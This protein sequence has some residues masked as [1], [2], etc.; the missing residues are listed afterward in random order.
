MYTTTPVK[1]LSYYLHCFE[2][3]KRDA[4]NGG[5]PHKPVLLLSIIQLFEQGIF[6]NQHVFLLPEL[7]A[8]FKSNWNRLVHTTHHPIFALPYYHM[9]SEPF[10]MLIP[11]AGCEKWIESKG[12]MR[13]LRN[14]ITAV[15]YAQIDNELAVLLCKKESRDILK[16]HLVEHYFSDIKS[17]NNIVGIDDV[18]SPSIL[19][20]S[21]EEYRRKILDLKSRLNENA[22]QEE[23]FIRG[24]LFKREIPKIYNTTCAISE[25]RVDSLFSIS[26]VDACHIVPFSEG[27]DD[28]FTNGISLCPNLHRAFDR[29][30]L[31]IS[32]NY[33]VL[34]NKNFIESNSVYN[35]KQFERKKITL[36]TNESHHPSQENLMAHRKK[37]GF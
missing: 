13:S 1:A 25:L 10:W 11:N 35:L 34:L 26:M 8:A 20:D 37:F 2:K 24:G 14:L 18:V 6:V 17:F 29:G 28:T 36:P 12:S 22:F 7:V 4:K 16:L 21:S 9:N 30:L 33:E 15:R 32:E 31:S 27:Y 3:L 19:N 5:A 23:V